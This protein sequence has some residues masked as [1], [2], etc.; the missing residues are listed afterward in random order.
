MKSHIRSI[1]LIYFYIF[2]LKWVTEDD[3]R[4]ICNQI[5]VG[6]DIKQLAFSEHKANGKS[7]GV[8]NIEFT[9]QES[10]KKAKLRLEQA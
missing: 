8:V 4:D 6:G 3:I 2:D 5:G 1:E 7:R 9:N 10:C